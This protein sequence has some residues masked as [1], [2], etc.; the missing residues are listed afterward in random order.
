MKKKILFP[1][2]WTVM[3]AACI[4]AN[5]FLRSSISRLDICDQDVLEKA[6]IRTFESYD[7]LMEENLS[8]EK[9]QEDSAYILRVIFEG[10]REPHNTCTF[11]TVRVLDVYK[12][13]PTLKNTEIYIYEY[14]YFVEYDSTLFY[15]SYHSQN[16]MSKQEEY[17]LFLT[18]FHFPEIY[19]PTE[20][21]SR[22]Y[23]LLNS[24]FNKFRIS[25]PI[26]Q[27]L[28]GQEQY[29][30]I[31]GFDI[32][33]EDQRIWDSYLLLRNQIMAFYL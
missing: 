28:T 16:L 20:R 31:V 29:L 13:D 26:V 7:A 14:P 10:V 30:D 12:G 19:K 17:I 23:V 25:E 18:P 4:A 11:S 32:L 8:V 21:E 15:E 1:L 5:L 3:I 24:Y 33:A 22:T 9:L 6:T 27:P 2:L